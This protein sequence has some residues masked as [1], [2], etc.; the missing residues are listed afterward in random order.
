MSEQTDLRAALY[1][2]DEIQQ[3]EKELLESGWGGYPWEH[4]GDASR[5]IAKLIRGL[6]FAAKLVDA[7]QPLSAKIDHALHVGTEE[8]MRADLEYL[9]K[10]IDDA[11][12]AAG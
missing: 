4:L 10:L 5:D 6:R 3:S 8:Q 9:R 7:L 12:K 11:V 1:L 2:A